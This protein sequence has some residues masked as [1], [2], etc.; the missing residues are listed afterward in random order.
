LN[1]LSKAAECYNV[2]KKETRH[3][4][5]NFIKIDDINNPDLEIYHKFRENA[6]ESD[7]SFVADSPKVVNELLKTSLEI[8]SILATQEYYEEFGDLIAQ[9]EIANLY[10]AE[11][12]V[13][14][15]IVGHTLHHNCMMHGIRPAFTPLS[16]MDNAVIMLDAITSNEN[17]GSIARSAAALGVNSYITAQQ[18]PHPYSRRSLRVSMGHVSKL[19]LNQYENIFDT[20]GELKKLGYTIVAAE[21]IPESIHLS[22]FE[23]PEKWVLLMGIEGKGLSDEI[24][25]ACDA[26]VLI[27]MAEGIRSLNVGV[28]A[29][30]MMYKFLH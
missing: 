30:V 19:K 9:K 25:S 6:F 17:I 27:E 29:S 2:I 13:I 15:S 28:A 12:K 7:H 8:K 22:K 10:V 26:C 23:V 24:I 16:E 21:V 1:R 3:F 18:S 20:I 5:K 4:M 11:K 14:E